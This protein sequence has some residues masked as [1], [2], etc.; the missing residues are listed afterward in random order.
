MSQIS[1]LLGAGFSVNR[2]YPAAVELNNKIKGIKS[3]D[4][5]I[6]TSGSFAWL[7]GK[8]D[9]FTQSTNYYGSKLFI[10]DYIE[11]YCKHNEFDYEQF[12]DDLQ[13][14]RKD[15]N[16]DAGFVYFCNAFKEKYNI[17]RD[18]R[19]ILLEA[20]KIF[21]QI[22]SALIRDSDGNKYYDTVSHGHPNWRNYSGFT[23][24]LEAWSASDMI[25]V[26]TLN[27]D[28]FFETLKSSDILKGELD[29]GFTELGSPFYGEL[30][31]S[32]VRLRH[33]T[34]SFQSKFRLY[35]LHGSLD[36][37]PF[38]SQNGAVE[39]IKIRYGV[40]LEDLYKEV[41]N[42]KDELSYDNDFTNYHSDF[43]S[44]TTSKILRYREPAYYEPIFQQ[45]EKNLT[46]SAVLV[47]IGYGC[48]DS[49]IN[50]LIDKHFPKDREVYI[51]DPFPGDKCQNLRIKL[52]ATLITK[53]PDK[54]SIEDFQ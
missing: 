10:L 50:D 8:A 2:G 25:H 16:A 12:Y 38:H 21:N 24:C 52:N 47:I 9:P 54:L 35:K 45:F 37:Y 3:N 5:T 30:D 27:H 4:F 40:S 39:Y 41:R 36:Q 31:G 23:R 51:V 29:D 6:T 14:N 46:G 15:E 20:N 28:L 11:F 48:G 33:F 42:D 49:E 44:G 53:D 22:I 17:Q 32:K 43:L 26:H 1:L 19:D 7:D 13:A 34:N 18:L